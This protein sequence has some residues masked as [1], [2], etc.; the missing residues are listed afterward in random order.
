MGN[1]TAILQSL[2]NGSL[3]FSVLSQGVVSAIVPEFN[4]LGL[5]YLF[6]DTDTAWRVLDGAVGQQLVQKSATRGLVVLSFWDM[7]I[8]QISNSVRPIM[9]PADLVGLRIRIPPDRLAADFVS[10]LGGKS[11]EINFSDL[12]KAL[13]YGVVDGQDHPLVNFQTARLYEVQK[14]I[15]LTGHRYSVYSFLMSKLAWDGL[16]AADKEIVMAAAKEAT[17]YQRALIQNAEEEAYRDLVARGVRI[18][19]VDIRPFITA[20]APIYDKW[21]ASPIGDF[22]RAVVKAAQGKQ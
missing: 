21:Y 16:S 1:Q 12:Y 9:K 2:K 18:N 3:D 5:P 8:R 19:K 20:T 7:E 10:A 14:F 6:P 11:Q 22:V 15:S 13:Q 17:R 4:A